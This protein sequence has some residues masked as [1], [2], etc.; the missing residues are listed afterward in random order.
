M[1]RALITGASSGLGEEFAW[2][3]AE[4]RHDLVLVARDEARLERLA[5]LLGAAGGIEVEVLP[6]D[7]SDRDQLERVAQRLRDR[8]A[9]VGLLVNN[10]GYGLH[11]SFIDGDI[12]AEEQLLDV[13]VRAVLVLSHAGAETMVEKGR[14][15]VLNVSSVAALT[16]MGTYAAHKMWVRTFT[17]ALATELRGTGVTATVLSPGFVRTEFHDRAGWKNMPWPDE[18]FLD[19][20]R[21]VATA[22]NDVRRGAVISTPSLRYQVASAVAR[23]S[24]RSAVRALTGVRRRIER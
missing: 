12:Q 16:A 4:A 23:L 21:V 10:A 22:L 6:A 11:Q 18:A 14:G 1:G 8:S 13:L 9:P 5:A 15:A 17:E 2:Q 20:M 19:P 7:L 3:L 24:P